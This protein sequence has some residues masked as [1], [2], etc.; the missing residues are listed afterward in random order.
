[1][2]QLIKKIIGV[3]AKINFAE[4][5]KNGAV[6]IDVRT[7]SEFQRGHIEDS[8]NIPL[9]SLNANLSKLKKD[10][11]VITCCASGIRSASAKNILSANGLPDDFACAKDAVNLNNLDDWKEFHDAELK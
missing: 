7:K 5:H 9:D 3:S 10:K 11:P 2:V 8:I 1:M 4:L 6:I